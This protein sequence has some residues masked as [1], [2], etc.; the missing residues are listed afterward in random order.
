MIHPAL[1]CPHC[2]VETAPP[3]TPPPPPSAA[4]AGWIVLVVKV[5]HIGHQV[6]H[7]VHVWQGVD[8]CHLVTCLYLG[9]TSQGINTS[10]IHGAG[11]TNSFPA[12][13]SECQ[14]RVQLVFYLDQGIQHHWATILQVHPEL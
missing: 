6:L 1:P 7:Y 4:R 11:A 10:N 3:H 5:F 2:I 8:L 13:P 9:Q 12:G 14:R